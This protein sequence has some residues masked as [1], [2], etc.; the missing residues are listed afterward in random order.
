MAN[1][2]R[3]HCVVPEFWKLDLGDLKGTK[4]FA[5][6]CEKELGRLDILVSGDDEIL[7]KFDLEQHSGWSHFVHVGFESLNRS[8][9]RVSW[10]ENL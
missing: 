6:R 8:S 5:E 4:E 2:E 3:Q 7:Q 10:M 1:D 9:M